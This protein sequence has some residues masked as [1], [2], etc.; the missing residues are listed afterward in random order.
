MFQDRSQDYHEPRDIWECKMTEE[1]M[2]PEETLGSCLLS[3]EKI[4]VG[5]SV[6]RE[7]DQELSPGATRR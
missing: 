6:D 1:S 7:R 5:A 3:L 4:A 2:C